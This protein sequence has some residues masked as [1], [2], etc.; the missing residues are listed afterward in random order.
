MHLISTISF[1]WI[2]IK[3]LKIILYLRSLNIII[4]RKKLGVLTWIL[5]VYFQ[6]CGEEVRK[7]KFHGKTMAAI[8]K[9]TWISSENRISEISYN[10]K[11][12]LGLWYSWK[13]GGTEQRGR[14]EKV[15]KIKSFSNFWAKL[16]HYWIP[17]IYIT[18]LKPG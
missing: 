4:F 13:G 11:S 9:L 6:Q 5:I 10:K 8:V 12:S 17:D 3:F 15:R 18:T 2:Y 16:W 14:W 1:K 7:L